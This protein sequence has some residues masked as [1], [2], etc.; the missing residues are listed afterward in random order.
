[1]EDPLYIIIAACLFGGLVV[2]G[3]VGYLIASRRTSAAIRDAAKFEAE[4]AAARNRVADAEL[5][6]RQLAEKDARQQERLIEAERAKTK[7]ETEL[8]ELREEVENAGLRTAE[9]EKE[10]RRLSEQ[11]VELKTSNADLNAKYNEAVKAIEEQKK[12]IVE[13]NEKLREAFESLSSEALR[14]NNSSFLEMA[15]QT[16]ET[17]TKE[18]AAELEKRKQAIEHLIKPLGDSLSQFDK[19]LGEIELKREGA[20]AEMRTLLDAIRST[21]TELGEGTKQLV[22]ALKTS[23]VRGKYGEISLRRVVEVA[24]LSPY[25]DFQEQ[26]S[27]S[28]EDGKLRPDMIISLPGGRQLI[29]DAKVP[30]AAYMRAFETENDEERVRELAEHAKAVRKHLGDLSKR[31][32]WEQLSDT[33]DFVVMYMQIES[34]FGAA[35]MADPKLIEDG[36]SNRV[37]LATP[38]TLITMLR[39]VGFMWQQERMAESI[40]EMRDA[41][42]EL[43]KRTTTLLEHFSN[44]GAGLNRAVNSYNQAVGSLESRFITQLETIKKISG[45]LAK[46]NIPTLKPIETAI[47]PVTKSLT[48]G[49]DGVIEVT[50]SE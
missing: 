26:V 45:T 8:A 17:Q 15:K 2:G 20:Y 29:L 1:M 28:T 16:L 41:G 5:Q 49:D 18:S 11:S 12:F 47:R 42:I 13:A 38:S 37:V 27:F 36:I 25:C 10:I 9:L 24:G 48:E 19:K 6:I 23:H 34:S 4:A 3:A 33:V 7:A 30:L 46:E 14:R 44:V 43:Y 50:A 32:Y 40:Y 35:L 39:T 31:S 22:G 21:T